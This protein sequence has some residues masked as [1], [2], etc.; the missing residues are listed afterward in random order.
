MK[1]N[2]SLGAVQTKMALKLL[3][4]KSSH[5]LVSFSLIECYVMFPVVE[6]V[7]SARLQICG[8]NGWILV[9]FLIFMFFEH[10]EWII[11]VFPSNTG[12]QGWAMGS[13]VYKFR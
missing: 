6:M 10:S 12:I 5:R 4:W 9:Y 8:G 3:K 2:T 11:F 1:P 13:I 7:P